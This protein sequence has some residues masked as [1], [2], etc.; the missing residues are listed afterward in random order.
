[1]PDH[2]HRSSGA[3]GPGPTELTDAERAPASWIAPTHRQA[4]DWGLVLTAAAIPHRIEETAQGW[5]LSVGFADRARAARELEAFRREAVPPEET[6]E[7][8]ATVV[9]HHG[10]AAIGLLLAT[11]LVGFYLVTGP[12]R[13][14]VLWFDAGSAVA[15]RIV[16]GEYWRTISALTLHAD[17]GHVLANAVSFAVFVGAL[18]RVLGIGVGLWV[19][20]AAGALGNVA[21][22]HAYGEH[23]ASVGASTAIFG[24][25]GALAGVQIR[26]RGRR[27]HRRRRRWLPFAAGLAL[28][29]MLGS[30]PGAD[31]A[32]HLFGFLAGAVL[33]LGVA[34]AGGRPRSAALQGTLA[35]AAGM[36]IV[37]S[38]RLALR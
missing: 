3:S 29:A 33:G 27:P 4:E 37:A 26:R 14:G 16:A 30:A 13:D 28:L 11:G 8:S 1:M 10:A 35:L 20:L 15:E 34:A 6:A 23:H 7:A 5:V 25:V 9:E 31:V 24:A 18:C 32:A 17:A 22:A 2:S 19:T 36:A 12:R 21:T 38:W